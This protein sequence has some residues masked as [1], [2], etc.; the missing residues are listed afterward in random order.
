[1]LLLS[2]MTLGVFIEIKYYNM[3]F[4]IGNTNYFL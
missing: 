2:M 1:M 3:E 4:K